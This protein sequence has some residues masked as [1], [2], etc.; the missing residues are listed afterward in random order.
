MPTVISGTRSPRFYDGINEPTSRPLPLRTGLGVN[1]CMN[2]MPFG[3]LVYATVHTYVRG[4]ATKMSTLS[5]NQTD[6]QEYNE[7]EADQYVGLFCKILQL[8]LTGIIPCFQAYYKW[9]RS[10]E[11]GLGAG[12][13]EYH[14]VPAKA[15][16]SRFRVF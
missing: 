12:L 1:L 10:T 14:R 3:V 11:A 16:L 6:L 8:R 2:P 9:A 13:D 7:E 4:L 5:P 15:H